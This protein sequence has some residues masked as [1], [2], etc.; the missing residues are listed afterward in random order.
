MAHLVTLARETRVD[1]WPSITVK[2]QVMMI[3]AGCS[4]ASFPGE[5]AAEELANMASTLGCRS[6]FDG[7]MIK[8]LWTDD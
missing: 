3:N 1:R 6:L 8:S 4:R 7:S 2:Q 5:M